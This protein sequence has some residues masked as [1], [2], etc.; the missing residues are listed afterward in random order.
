MQTN[1]IAGYKERFQDK[2]K[3]PRLPRVKVELDTNP[4]NRYLT[5]AIQRL[6]DERRKERLPKEKSVRE[7]S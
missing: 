3:Y 2:I 5:P 6:V 1:K 7:S 4:W